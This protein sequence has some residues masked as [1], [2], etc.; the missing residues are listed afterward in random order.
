ML[1]K[2]GHTYKKIKKGQTNSVEM[3]CSGQI[4]EYVHIF[5]MT[6]KDI[7]IQEF[8]DETIHRNCW[9]DVK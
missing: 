1:S 4:I 8:T 7:D 5:G 6:L 9:G 3:G 2:Q